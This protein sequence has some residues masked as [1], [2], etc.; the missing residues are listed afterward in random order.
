MGP[1][2]ENVH[3]WGNIRNVPV[4]GENFSSV[5]DEVDEWPST[6]RTDRE[7]RTNDF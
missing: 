7:N 4:Y 1:F 3:Q 6:G 2:G 5:E